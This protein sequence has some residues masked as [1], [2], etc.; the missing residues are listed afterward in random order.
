MTTKRGRTSA[1]SLQSVALLPTRRPPEPPAHLQPT[2]RELWE[3][4]AL[5]LPHDYFRPSD[6][7][8][9]EAYVLTCTR[10]RAIDGLIAKMPVSVE[11]E[12]I[13]A[14]RLS[15]E[16]GREMASLAGKLRLCPSSRTRAE[17]ASLKVA[18]AGPRPWDDPN[19]AAEYFTD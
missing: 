15:G 7:P 18:H 9:L 2:A 10:K 1:A 11:A 13:S 14:L 8:L 6:L 12:A 5:S 19:P 16:L 17:S 3:N 4:I